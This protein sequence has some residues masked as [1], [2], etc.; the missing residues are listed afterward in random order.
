MEHYIKAG[1]NLDAILNE[2]LKHLITSKIDQ[3]IIQKLD[4]IIVSSLQS[5]CI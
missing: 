5:D 3:N 4:K 1:C 2:W